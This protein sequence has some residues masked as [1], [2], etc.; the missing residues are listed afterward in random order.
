MT[1]TNE[2]RRASFETNADSTSTSSSFFFQKKKNTTDRLLDFHLPSERERQLDSPT[3]A[4]EARPCAP[5]PLQRGER[6]SEHRGDA[7]Q[8]RGKRRRRRRFPQRRGSAGPAAQTRNP[9]WHRHRGQGLRGME[10]QKR[11]PLHL[12][13]RITSPPRAQPAAVGKGQ[14]ARRL[15]AQAKRRLVREGLL[16]RLHVH[17]GPRDALHGLLQHAAQREVRARKV[18]AELPVPSGGVPREVGAAQH[19][20]GR[21]ARGVHGRG[22]LQGKDAPDQARKHRLVRV[23]VGGRC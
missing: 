18:H 6:R 7:R 10:G 14:P 21:R 23:D 3:G 17:R 22:R 9:H 4:P 13:P 1:T 15:E 2:R 12:G 19:R 16:Q 20:D 5:R 8:R 11:H